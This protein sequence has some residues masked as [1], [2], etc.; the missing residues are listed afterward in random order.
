M[1]A[2][3]PSTIPESNSHARRQTS[4]ARQVTDSLWSA[5]LPALRRISVEVR[6]E[7]VVL[8]G[9]VQ[10]FYERQIAVG[11]VA[12]VKG[13]RRLVD[14]LSVRPASRGLAQI[15]TIQR[16]RG[17]RSANLQGQPSAAIM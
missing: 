7:T 8:R 5:S 13:I 1:I 12:G 6:K 2:T 15:S 11:R 10:T 3:T 4:L 14:A 17:Q 16:P 9:E